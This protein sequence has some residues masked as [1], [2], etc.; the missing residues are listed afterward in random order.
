ME[1]YSLSREVRLLPDA[2]YLGSSRVAQAIRHWLRLVAL[3]KQPPSA[4]A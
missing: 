3:G 1:P 4:T 2:D